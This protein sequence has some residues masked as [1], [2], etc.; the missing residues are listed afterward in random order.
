MDFSQ[1]LAKF[2]PN[3]LTLWGFMVMLGLFVAVFIWRLLWPWFIKDYWPVRSAERKARLDAEIEA[4]RTKAMAQQTMRDTL[5]EIRTAISQMVVLN[6]TM[7]GQVNGLHQAINMLDVGR[8]VP[9]AAPI[10]KG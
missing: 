8:G 7:L 1:W 3:E 6:Q 2:N 5:I 4:I 10:P 9:Q